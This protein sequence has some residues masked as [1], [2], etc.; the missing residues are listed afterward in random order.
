MSTDSYTASFADPTFRVLRAEDGQTYVAGIAI[1]M[2][3]SKARHTAVDI[4]QRAAGHIEARAAQRD[5]A[6]GERSMA[7][8]VAAFNAL[9]GH[10]LSE[11][12]GWMF[13]VALKAARAC[14]TPT[15]QPDDYEDLA[16]YGALAGESVRAVQP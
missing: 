13:M 9:T 11:R 14:C 5:Q 2:P 4:L 3:D 12:D 6:Q 10:Q 15:G 8:T 16:A 7:R 1:G